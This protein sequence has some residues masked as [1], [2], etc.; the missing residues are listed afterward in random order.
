MLS[1]MQDLRSGTPLQN[2]I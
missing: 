1:N 2:E